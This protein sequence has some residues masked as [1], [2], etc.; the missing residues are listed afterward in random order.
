MGCCYVINSLLL[1]NDDKDRDA[2]RGHKQISTAAN[3]EKNPC[4]SIPATI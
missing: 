3:R 2:Y 1:N 4:R